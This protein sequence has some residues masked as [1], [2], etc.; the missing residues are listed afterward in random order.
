MGPRWLSGRL[1]RVRRTRGARYG[2][3]LL[4]LAAGTGIGLAV[5]TTA[6]G[7]TVCGTTG[8]ISDCAQWGVDG[9]ATRLAIENTGTTTITLFTFT[10]PSGV[11]VSGVAGVASPN[12]CT[13][14]ANQ[15]MCTATIAPGQT[16]FADILYA[17]NQMP[18]VGST[19]A[20]TMTDASG[21]PPEQTVP[22]QSS[23]VCGTNPCTISSTGSSSS[24]STPPSTST[25]SST[26]TST[27]PP[28]SACQAKLKVTKLL[29]SSKYEIKLHRDLYVTYK[30]AGALAYTIFVHNDSK[31]PA[32]GVVIT[33][34]LP[35]DFDCAGGT[36]HYVTGGKPVV[37]HV[38]C[39]G[40]GRDILLDI[41]ML[42]ADQ[43]ALVEL[44]GRFLLERA[45][46]NTARATATNA[47]GE[48]SDHI[49]VEVVSK[50]QF[51]ADRG[52][53]NTHAAAR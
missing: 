38:H 44:S 24:T 29:A 12:H 13:W 7:D 46:A 27:S 41:G 18:P 51:D 34:A 9:Y 35:H 40:E 10:L 1:A 47:P 25:M 52:R 39:K 50:K 42:G 23:T 37:N 14:T 43:T 28:T 6:F 26:S 32:T 31:C 19:G 20:L 49:H 53:I 17:M 4:A 8:D 48:H 16:F 2:V 21:T 33:D 3:M 22:L 36:W 11:T 5:G 15:I 30:D 45:T